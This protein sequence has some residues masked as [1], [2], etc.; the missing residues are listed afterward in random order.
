MYSVWTTDGF[1]LLLED[2]F[3]KL[4]AYWTA[5]GLGPMIEYP[6]AGRPFYGPRGLKHTSE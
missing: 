5:V 6:N 4:D 3:R 1:Y 2:D